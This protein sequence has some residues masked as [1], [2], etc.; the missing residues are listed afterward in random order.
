MGQNGTKRK[1]W[2][3][4]KC[5]CW[6][7]TWNI[8]ITCHTLYPAEPPGRHKHL[9]GSRYVCY[10]GNAANN[11]D[12]SYQKPYKGKKIKELEPQCHTSE[13]QLPLSTDSKGLSQER[14]LLK[15]LPFHIIPITQHLY[16]FQHF[17][18][19]IIFIPFPW[20]LPVNLVCVYFTNLQQ[21]QGNISI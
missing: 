8:K 6:I 1:E 21:T 14:N 9:T 19:Q 2:H 18:G 5:P 7:Q 11:T 15:A 16:F 3:I 17:L 4:M 13:I 12:V 10:H 20:I